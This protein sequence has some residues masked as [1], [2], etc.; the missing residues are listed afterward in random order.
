MT[1][2]TLVVTKADSSD[3]PLL[4]NL[5]NHYVY[6]MSE[7]FK[8]DPDPDGSFSYDLDEFWSS[9]HHVFIAR[10]GDSPVGV[11]LVQTIDDEFDLKEFFVLRR[12]RRSG[13]GQA[14]SAEVWDRLP[15]K[16]KVRVF[17]GNKPAVPFWK[18]VVSEYTHNKYSEDQLKIN[19]K[20]WIHF[21]FQSPVEQ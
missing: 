13:V 14:F 12:Y 3:S 19:G 9:G 8:F 15:G 18:E 6:D 20:S 4:R 11:A 10:F 7:W 21:C 5:L 1:D 16:W 2:P 17:T